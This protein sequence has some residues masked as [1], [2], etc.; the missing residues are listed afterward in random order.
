MSYP[1]LKALVTLSFSWWEFSPFS[2]AT[3]L[4]EPRLLSCFD[5]QDAEIWN[6]KWV[7]ILKCGLYYEENIICSVAKCRAVQNYFL[8]PTLTPKLTLLLC[9]PGVVH[10]WNQLFIA[11]SLKNLLSLLRPPVA[12]SRV[13]YSQP[14]IPTML[15]LFSNSATNSRVSPVAEGRKITRSLTLSW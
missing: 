15:P 12:W 8:T 10:N 6:V 1:S 4:F 9:K 13:L 7:L 3:S 2:L 5:S 14:T 11:F